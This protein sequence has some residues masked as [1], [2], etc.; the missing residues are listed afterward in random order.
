M[1][2]DLSPYQLA[3]RASRYGG[4]GHCETHTHYVATEPTRCYNCSESNPA[5]ELY[6]NIFEGELV[7]ESPDGLTFCGHSCC[8]EYRDRAQAARS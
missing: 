5:D 2:A 1:P 6:F 3:K 8:N 7:S 4:C